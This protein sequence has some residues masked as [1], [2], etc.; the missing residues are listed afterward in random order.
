MVTGTASYSRLEQIGY[1]Q[2]LAEDQA[3]PTELRERVRAELQ[4]IDKGAAVSPI[5][6]QVR[7]IVTSA[8]AE[9]DADLEALAR[10]ALN[11]V[12]ASA[13]SKR[14]KRSVVS[15]GVD[16]VRYPVRA[17][18]LTW[19]ELA[20]WWLHYDATELAASLTDEQLDS[21]LE[22][23]AG[24]AAFAAQLRAARENAPTGSTR[25]HLRAI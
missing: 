3:Q 16:Q 8:Q 6:Q 1:L 20:S 18:V 15:G 2:Q 12:A 17:F 4:R 21:F 24:T 7:A 14:A 22:T 25:G 9:R 13:A 5:Y 19:G 10:D 23:S 11:R